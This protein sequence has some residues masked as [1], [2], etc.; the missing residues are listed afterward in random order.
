M[1]KYKLILLAL[2]L[3]SGFALYSS[4]YFAWLTATPLSAGQLARAQY[5]CYFWFALFVVAILLSI[6]VV[7][8][9]IRLRRKM[10]EKFP[11]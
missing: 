4:L 5:D 3:V 6:F 9:I 11:V 8:R 2:I 7:V 10:R 1:T